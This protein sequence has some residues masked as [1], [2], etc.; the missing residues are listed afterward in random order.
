MAAL[1]ATDNSAGVALSSQSTTTARGR[2][3]YEVY[4][5]LR[6]KPGM[7][8]PRSRNRLT[9]T[10]RADSIPSISHSCSDKIATWSVLG[11][12]GAL[13]SRIFERPIYLASIVIGDIPRT[14]P[15]E[16]D[17]TRYRQPERP[18]RDLMAEECER[19]FFGRLGAIES[20]C[21]VDRLVQGSESC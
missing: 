14:A 12:Q 16:V 13:A 9:R 1:K 6:T 4:G 11:L 19:A 5:A 2:S 21:G 8:P 10:G 7:H 17:M 15:T 20:E 3:G 18:W